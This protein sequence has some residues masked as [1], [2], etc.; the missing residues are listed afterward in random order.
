MQQCYL[1]HLESPIGNPDNK[2]AQAQ[3]YIGV[4][5][6]LTS[7]IKRHKIGQGAAML[8][9]ANNRGIRW[10]V[11]RTWDNGNRA[12]EKKLKARK[13]AKQLC[14]VC[15]GELSIDNLIFIAYDNPQENITNDCPF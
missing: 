10:A 6:N 13:N 2:R 7:R 4:T 12:M 8:R 3:H 14:P 5:K 1:I 15:R 9:A 11:V